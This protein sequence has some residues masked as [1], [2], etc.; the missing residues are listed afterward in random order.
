MQEQLERVQ[1]M[2]QYLVNEGD[3]DRRREV[4]ARLDIEVRELDQKCE[5]LRSKDALR[6]RQIAEWRERLSEEFATQR[7]KQARLTLLNSWLKVV[8]HTRRH[9]PP[10]N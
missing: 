9:Q 1:G 7:Q 10:Q 5:L 4:A 3:P 2:S 8:T 6:A